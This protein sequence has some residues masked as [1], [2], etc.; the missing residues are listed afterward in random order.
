[1]KYICL[2]CDGG[3]FKKEHVEEVEQV[4]DGNSIFIDCEMMVCQ[5]CG[6]KYWTEDQA[7]EMVKKVSNKI[8]RKIGAAKRE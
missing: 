5:N 4:I 6:F 7:D 3:D 8:G 2:L 1:M